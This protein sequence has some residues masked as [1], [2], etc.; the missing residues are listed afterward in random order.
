MLS[1]SGCSVSFIMWLSKFNWM[2]EI[3]QKFVENIIDRLMTKENAKLVTFSTNFLFCVG[4]EGGWGNGSTCAR[5]DCVD[6]WLWQ[7]NTSSKRWQKN[8]KIIISSIHP[9][10]HRYL[11]PPGQI[12]TA[13]LLCIVCC[14]LCAPISKELHGSNT[15]STVYCEQ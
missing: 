12:V 11:L 8:S 15:K 2:S 13:L 3:L 14:A 7:Y 5:P 1:V 6:V 4:C 10:F 9:S